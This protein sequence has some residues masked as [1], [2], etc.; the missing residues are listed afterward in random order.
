M[1]KTQNKI[2]VI[3]RNGYELFQ[4]FYLSFT[5]FVDFVNKTINA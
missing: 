5:I 4:T 2:E 1:T 3:G